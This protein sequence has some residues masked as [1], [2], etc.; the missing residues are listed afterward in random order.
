MEKP[1]SSARQRQLARQSRQSRQPMAVR[2]SDAHPQKPFTGISLNILQKTECK[3]PTA[4]KFVSLALIVL[5]LLIV[6][7]NIFFS[8][9]LPP[10][11]F[12]LDNAVG[13]MPLDEAISLLESTW[14]QD[15]TMTLSSETQEWIVSPTQLGI[16]LDAEASIAIAMDVGVAGIPFGVY[17]DPV[18]SIDR[19]RMLQFLQYLSD[20]IYDPPVNARYEW[21]N[22]STIGI[23]GQVGTE[24]DVD[25]TLNQIYQ[26]LAEGPQFEFLLVTSTITPPSGNPEILLEEAE[27]FITAPF[28]LSA[29]DPFSDRSFSFTA[30][31]ETLGT[32]IEASESQLVAVQET[33]GEY[34]ETVN[35]SSEVD[36][37]E[38]TYLDLTE[39][40]QSV[41]RALSTRSN[42]AQIML[43]SRPILY[44]VNSGDTG[45]GIARKAGIPFFL[46]EQE[47]PDIDL[48]ILSPGD[49]VT[50]P[51]RDVTLP[52]QVISNKR[53]IVDLETQ[54][55][56]A[57]EDDELVFNWQISS[58]ISEAPT[59]PGVYQILSHEP[60]AS[61]SSYSLCGEAGCGQWEL[62]WFMGIYE[63]VP[64]L[65]NGF[66]GAVLLPNGTFLGGNNVG[67][68]YTLGCVMSRDD[69]ARQ[70]YEW[71][72]E[73]TIVE[74]ISADYP[75]QSELARRVINF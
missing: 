51:S 57:Y 19:D 34:I 73:G 31:P 69:Q 17:V 39:V 26:S 28:E 10:N 45:Y 12:I 63:V 5:I 33:L 66:H 46:I 75:P 56:A 6:V 62:N 21:R 22:N 2:N 64:G 68:P 23:P 27:K 71:A 29:Y 20:E 18:I 25:A 41:N 52:I 48:S 13:G 24:L 67:T 8:N 44:E 16:H 15:R 72:N 43:R 35:H 70:L 50:L 65:V 14:A 9:R 58:G 74:I 1:K 32:W 60:V 54:T 4:I 40:V 11:V 59:S 55:L 37:P 49:V 7:L 36:L 61:G 30:T 38:N 53:I 42:S 3:H 47:N